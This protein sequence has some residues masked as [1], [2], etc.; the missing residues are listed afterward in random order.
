MAEAFTALFIFDS[1]GG[2]PRESLHPDF[3]AQGHLSPTCQGGNNL[4]DDLK[5]LLS[6]QG[7]FSRARQQHIHIDN[8]PILF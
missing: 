7:K 1:S 5:C 2:A 6:L 4:G 3:I 8:R